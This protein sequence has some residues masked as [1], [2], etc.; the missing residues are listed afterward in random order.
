VSGLNE[1]YFELF[2]L[3][4][5]F[6]IDKT[7]LE[8]Q[9]RQIQSAAHPDRFVT[10][11]STEKLQS[12]QLA[13]LANE[14]Y[15]TLKKPASRAKYLLTLNKIDAIEETNTSMPADFLMQQMEWREALEDYKVAK[16]IDGLENLMKEMLQVAS[17]LTNELNHLFDEKNDLTSATA[18]TRKLIFIDKVCEDINKAVTQIE[19]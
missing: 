12:M 14:A 13:T 15:Q 4:Q 1:N 8:S 2:A 3:K 6:T 19:D 7:A 9:Y 16:D 11:S 10:A 5:C 17:A 18:T